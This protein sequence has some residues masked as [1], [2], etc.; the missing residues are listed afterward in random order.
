MGE[1]EN[2]KVLKEEEDNG[3][4]EKEGVEKEGGGEG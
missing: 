2:E 4:M 3:E 1:V